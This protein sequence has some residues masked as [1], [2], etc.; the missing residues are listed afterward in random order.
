MTLPIRVAVIGG[1]IFGREHVSVYAGMPSVRLVAI[2]EPNEKRRLEWQRD[3]L[4][5]TAKIFSSVAE[6]LAET[7]LDAASIV[8]PS[9]TR[10]HIAT[11][12]MSAGVDVL[13]EKPFADSPEDAQKFAEVAAALGRKCLPGHLLRFSQGHQNL[14]TVISQPAFG[15]VVGVTLSRNRSRA[16]ISL[17]PDIHPA[18]LLGVHDFDLAIWLTARPVTEV[19]AL[20]HRNSQGKVDYFVAH[21]LH[22]GGAISTIQVSCLLS[23]GDPA[24]VDDSVSVFG[25]GRTAHLETAS[26]DDEPQHFGF[27]IENAPLVAELQYFL[28]C[29]L[30][31]QPSTLC[32][33]EEGVHVVEIAQAVLRSASNGGEITRLRATNF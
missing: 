8:T 21:C 28:D 6:M 5:K 2:V 24:Q 12:L 15:S 20:E 11:E 13:V 3:P 14:K 31:N 17:Y 27:G 4:A 9:K 18:F 7:K 33:P 25:T 26:V 32:T 19:S 23:E 10:L 30:K 16:L 29:V 1:G 22:N